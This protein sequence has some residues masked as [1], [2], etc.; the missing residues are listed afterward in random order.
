LSDT[1]RCNARGTQTPRFE[2]VLR[3]A[4][5]CLAQPFNDRGLGHPAALAHRLQ[6][7]ATA[8]RFKSV[9]QRRHDARTAGAQRVADRDGP[10]V[11]VRL[12]Q[13]APVSCAQATVG[14]RAQR[15]VPPFASRRH[16]DY[17]GLSG[18]FT[19]QTAGALQ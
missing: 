9:D 5:S 14:L 19:E 2:G 7:V 4:D 1:V 13:I 18:E 8:A 12:G 10:A 17:S 6:T 3:I 11:N 15:R 16:V